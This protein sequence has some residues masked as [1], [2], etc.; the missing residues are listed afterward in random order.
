M[1]AIWRDSVA[2]ET[3]D[4]WA[5]VDPVFADRLPDAVQLALLRPLQ[6]APAVAALSV[7]DTAGVVNTLASSEIENDEVVADDEEESEADD[8]PPNELARP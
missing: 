8:M 6:P 5:H 3:R 7:T 2:A 1:L 4:G